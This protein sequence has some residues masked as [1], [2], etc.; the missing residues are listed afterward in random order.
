MMTD[1]IPEVE[2]VAEWLKAQLQNCFAINF[3]G[4][5]AK[6]MASE[7]TLQKALIYL[8]ETD[9]IE[10]LHPV[11]FKS[12]DYSVQGFT[13]HAHEH[14]RLKRCTDNDYLWETTLNSSGGYGRAPISP[15]IP[16]NGAAKKDK[17]AKLAWLWV[18][19]P[20]MAEA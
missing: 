2:L 13:F 18:E 15:R 1:S 16:E 10:R 19:G 4:L 3:D 17:F 7:L 9:Q 11:G 12:A 14:Y 20:E 6:S 5:K 8:H